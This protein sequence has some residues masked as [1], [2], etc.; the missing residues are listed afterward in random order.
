MDCVDSTYNALRCGL[1]LMRAV[2]GLHQRR[3]RSSR[4]L[5]IDL[6]WRSGSDADLINGKKKVP[7]NYHS[8]PL[9]SKPVVDIDDDFEADFQELKDYSD[10]EMEIDVKPFAFSASKKLQPSRF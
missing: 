1:F 4:R 8:K 3:A 7:R 10:D 5:T 2:T 6:L 9:R